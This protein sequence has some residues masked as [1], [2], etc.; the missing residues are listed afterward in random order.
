MSTRTNI[1]IVDHRTHS[2][3]ILYRHCDGYLA[4]TGADVAQIVHTLRAE[5]KSTGRMT[6]TRIAS[7]FLS[8]LYPADD[9]TPAR[10]IYSLQD[11]LSGDIEHLYLI[12][13]KHPCCTLHGLYDCLECGKL[14]YIVI[15]HA[16][17]VYDE[18][19]RM[20]F[21]EDLEDHLQNLKLADFVLKINDDR[22]QINA[23]HAAYA[24][25]MGEICDPYP[26]LVL[27]GVNGPEPTPE[28]TPDPDPEPN[29][30]A[31]P[32]SDPQPAA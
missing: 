9:H 25:I 8:E 7:R 4:E 22:Q 24:A 27:P 1:K 32:G 28:P 30:A 3:H 29:P 23:F 31:A 17:N 21:G 13:I 19:G 15:Y 11:T 2:T 14:P 16:G 18:N 10:P 12:R 6:T 20:I 26:M 5:L